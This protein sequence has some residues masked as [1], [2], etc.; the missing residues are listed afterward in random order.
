MITT[1][2]QSSLG[3]W[4]NCPEIFRR[5]YL[6][7]DIIP[8]GLAAHVGTGIHKA[9]EVNYKA[10]ITTNQDQP[11]DVI[12]DAARDAYV[13]AVKDNGAYIPPDEMPSAKI[14]ADKALDDVVALAAVYHRDLAPLV[15]PVLVEKWVKI[16][17]PGLVPSISGTIDLLDSDHRLLDL[18]TASKAWPVSRAETSSQITIYHKLVE[19]ETGRAPTESRFDV[20]VKGKTPR[21]QPIITNRTDDDFEAVVERL[22]IMMDMIV[23]GLFPP[24][25]AGDWICGP[26]YCGY[27]YTCKHVPAHKKLL[28]KRSI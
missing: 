2:R 11:L 18:K 21:Y 25:R 8:P 23:A 22:K 14:M 27:W 10:K 7:G 9:A 13:H 4:E 26:K 19:V 12:Q 28:P 15:Q 16:Y 1:L 3:T 6:A 5:R 17:V 20:L 24:A